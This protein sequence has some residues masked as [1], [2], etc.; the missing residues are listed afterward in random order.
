[1]KIIA[2]ITTAKQDREV[3][4][5]KDTLWVAYGNGSGIT[6]YMPDIKKFLSDDNSDAVHYDS[7]VPKLEEWSEY[8]KPLKKKDNIKLFEIPVYP[9]SEQH[10]SL[11]IWGG[12]VKPSGKLYLIVTIEKNTIV[13]L[14]DNKNEAMHWLK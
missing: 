5:E 12:D 14:F 10:R 13:N 7:I 1:M 6:S 11:D 8:A 2:G 3:Y 4:F 9:R